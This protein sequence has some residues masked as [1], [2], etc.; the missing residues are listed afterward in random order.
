MATLISTVSYLREW[1]GDEEKSL[2]AVHYCR[3]DFS[4]QTLLVSG[5]FLQANAAALMMKSF[6]VIPRVLS[7]PSLPFGV[8]I[9]LSF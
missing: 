1:D 2:D 4:I 6:T 3:M 5:R 8:N 7:L 9:S